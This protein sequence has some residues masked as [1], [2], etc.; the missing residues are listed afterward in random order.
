M[1]SLPSLYMGDISGSRTCNINNNSLTVSTTS[2]IPMYDMRSNN[3]LIDSTMSHLPTLNMGDN[4]VE[5]ICNNNSDIGFTTSHLG[6]HI[7]SIQNQPISY[8]YTT[9]NQS[10]LCHIRS[11]HESLINDPSV[12]LNMARVPSDTFSLSL[13]QQNQPAFQEKSRIGYY[14]NLM[15]NIENNNMNIENTNHM[16]DGSSYRSGE[17]LNL[18]STTGMMFNNQV[19]LNSILDVPNA[20]FEQRLSASK[21]SVNENIFGSSSRTNITSNMVKG[22]TRSFSG[23]IGGFSMQE[24]HYVPLDSANLI[25]IKDLNGSTSRNSNASNMVEQYARFSSSGV[26][27]PVV[28]QEHNFLFGGVQLSN[29]EINNGFN[30]IMN[31]LQNPMTRSCVGS[32]IINED[33]CNSYH[34]GNY[35]GYVDGSEHVDYECGREVFYSRTLGESIGA[36]DP[37]KEKYWNEH[38]FWF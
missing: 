31:P 32:S 22:I 27:E 15:L 1:S 29:R 36:I 8:P 23:G 38:G 6:L 30:D 13:T 18:F 14:T 12:S 35:S 17:G 26:G 4:S 9:P 2:Y 24:E 7:S 25:A 11:E 28:P 33:V 21:C 5:S 20:T 37:Y 10:Q 3:N 19:S 16:G 34:Q